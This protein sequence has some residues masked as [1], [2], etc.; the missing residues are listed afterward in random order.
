MRERCRRGLL[1]VAELIR[2]N[3]G[4]VRAAFAVYH[5]TPSLRGANGRLQDDWFERLVELLTPSR[6]LGAAQS[7]QLA[8]VAG[9][10]VGTTTMLVAVWATAPPAGDIVALTTAALDQLD[11]IWPDW[12]DVP[13]A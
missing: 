3:A 13:V 10:L 2:A 8:T 4:S 5:A 11:P 12:L 6:R 1:A 9:A 7:L